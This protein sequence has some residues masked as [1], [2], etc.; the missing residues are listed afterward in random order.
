MLPAN[1]QFLAFV[2]FSLIAEAPRRKSL[3]I[4]INKWSTKVQIPIAHL[5]C[6]FINLSP[7][8]YLNI[9]NILRASAL[10][11]ANKQMLQCGKFDNR[12]AHLQLPKP[13]SPF[14]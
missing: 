4:L 13:A 9:P 14:I 3:I 2:Y 11:K 8:I 12:S 7:K 5:S 10:R 1:Y 6:L